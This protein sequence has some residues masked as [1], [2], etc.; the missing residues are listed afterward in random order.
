MLC[1]GGVPPIRGVFSAFLS[2]KGVDFS[3]IHLGRVCCNHLDRVPLCSKSI[4]TV[5]STVISN[6][7]KTPALLF[8]TRL[9][10]FAL[11]AN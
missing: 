1:T 4:S 8:P 9:R 7:C 6:L 5:Y 10:M 3:Q 11:H 2:G